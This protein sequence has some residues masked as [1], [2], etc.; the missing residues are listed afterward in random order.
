MKQNELEAYT[1]LTGGCVLIMVL[2]LIVNIFEWVTW[3]AFT[4][5]V[6]IGIIAS[7]LFEKGETKR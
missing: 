1:V 6:F 2:V 4:I 3:V 5:L 7:I